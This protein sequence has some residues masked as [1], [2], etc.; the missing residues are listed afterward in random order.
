M[1]P[2]PDGLNEKGTAAASSGERFRV[3]ISTG[4]VLVQHNLVYVVARERK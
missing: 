2:R 3:R 1:P 4:P